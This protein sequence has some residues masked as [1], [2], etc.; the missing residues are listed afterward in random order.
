MA[1]RQRCCRAVGGGGRTGW[2]DAGAA[3]AR[4]GTLRSRGGLADLGCGGL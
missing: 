4:C 1:G 2:G 3:R